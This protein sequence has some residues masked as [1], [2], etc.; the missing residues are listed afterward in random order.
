[1]GGGGRPGGSTGRAGCRRERG[2]EVPVLGRG[3]IELE[4]RDRV[5]GGEVESRGLVKVERGLRR[6]ACGGHAGGPM[7][8]V[9]MEED[10]PGGLLGLSDFLCKWPVSH[11]G[12]R[13]GKTIAR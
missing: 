7:R 8:E 3:L 2:S 9:K 13:P 5:G 11:A 12:N 6:A 10:A 4:F 1:M